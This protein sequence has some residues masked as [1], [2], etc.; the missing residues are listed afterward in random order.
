M[1]NDGGA[2]NR[3][4]RGWGVRQEAGVT[5]TELVVV[6]SIITIFAASSLPFLGSIIPE[7]K[8]RGGAEQVVEALRMAR[9]N[10]IGTTATYRVIFS[11]SQI[12]IICTTGTPAGNDCPA[13]RPPDLTEAVV[14]DATVNASPSEMQFDP[15]GTVLTGAGNVTVTYPSGTTWRVEVTTPGRVRSCTGTTACP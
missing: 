12:Q 1:T 8:T 4:A 15:K 2:R 7:L 10:S 9:Q 14:G 6:A 11:S 13:N 3:T 5:L